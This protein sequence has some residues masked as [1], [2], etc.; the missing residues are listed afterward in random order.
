MIAGQLEL[1]F[2]SEVVRSALKFH[3]EGRSPLSFPRIGSVADMMGI[4]TQPLLLPPQALRDQDAPF[5]MILND[6]PVV[7]QGVSAHGLLIA[8]PMSAKGKERQQWTDWKSL[9]E[10][11]EHGYPILLARRSRSPKGEPFGFRSFVPDIRKHTRTF[12][13]VI[14]ASFFIQVFALANPMIIQVIID[15]VIVQESLSTLDVLAALLIICTL[16]GAALTAI[17]TFLFTDATNRIDLSVGMK[18]LEHLYRLPL[19]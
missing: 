19:S 7:V 18:V 9:P 17:R 8:D 5:L 12:L 14:V 2:R 1:P 11:G 15:K 16:F 6:A 10:P 3:L 4:A 13:E